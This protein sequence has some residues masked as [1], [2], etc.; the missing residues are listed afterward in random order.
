MKF[1]SGFISCLWV[2]TLVISTV[3]A[4][5]C[6]VRDSN[7]NEIPPNADIRFDVADNAPAETQ[8]G[9]LDVVNINAVTEVESAFF[10]LEIVD[11]KLNIATTAE[12]ANVEQTSESSGVTFE[13]NLQCADG[14]PQTR[15]INVVLQLTNTYN[16]QFDEF[17]STFQLPMPFPPEI[18]INTA[19]GVTIA[20]FDNDIYN[21][22]VTFTIEDPSGN[23]YVEPKGD[24]TV[25]GSPKR[26]YAVALKS[27][28]LL[29]LSGPLEVTIVAQDNE[30][31]ER[32]TSRATVTI[33]VDEENSTPVT[34]GFKSNF[35]TAIDDDA[36]ATGELTPSEEI[37]LVEAPENPTGIVVTLREAPGNLPSFDDKFT[38][39]YDVEGNKVRIEQTL[40]FTEEEEVPPG[41]A[42]EIEVSEATSG[43]VARTV[44]HVS[45]PVEEC[46]VQTTET[47]ITCPTCSPGGGTCPTHPTCPSCPTP[48]PTVP[49]TCPTCAPCTSTTPKPPSNIEFVQ[50]EYSTTVAGDAAG[51]TLFTVE[52]VINDGTTGTIKYGFVASPELSSRLSMDEVTGELTLTRRASPGSYEFTLTAEIVELEGTPAT[53]LGFLDVNSIGECDDG[54]TCFKYALI[55]K[56]VE[57]GKETEDLIPGSQPTDPSCQFRIDDVDAAFDGWF[58][59]D[60]NTGALK[61]LS[62]INYE[63]D[64]FA[65]VEVPQVMLRLQ[66]EC[67]PVVEVK[68]SFNATKR[69]RLEAEVTKQQ[70][71][72]VL[73]I[74]NVNDHEPVFEPAE[75]RVGYPNRDFARQIFPGAIAKVQATDSDKGDDKKLRYRQEFISD[76]FDLDEITGELYPVD[77]RFSYDNIRLTILALD[78][79]GENGAKQGR[80]TLDIKMVSEGQ[81]AVVI[82]EGA[83]VD[84]ADTIVADLNTKIDSHLWGSLRNSYIAE[85]VEGR[86]G[87]SR[88]RAGGLLLVL[89]ALDKTN[90]NAASHEKIKQLLSGYQPGS[91]WTLAG[92]QT[93]EEAGGWDSSGE[94]SD[95][96]E[97]LTIA[98]IVLAVIVALCLIAIGGIIYVTIFRKRKLEKAVHSQVGVKNRTSFSKHRAFF[99]RFLRRKNQHSKNKESLAVE[100]AKRSHVNGFDTPKKDELMVEPEME[101]RRKSATV[102]FNDEPEVIPSNESVRL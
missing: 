65:D 83:T 59:I 67:S 69:A 17:I 23:F 96:D 55:T 36:F 62:A 79:E 98:V 49:P 29:N 33:E 66:V 44:L 52:A 89:Y 15:P 7:G 31:E 73:N 32:R 61:G 12:F 92:I 56:E 34:I 93:W 51:V 90:W 100:A 46:S 87:S 3:N 10:N 35:Y 74:L 1:R 25:G 95:P 27:K 77:G 80:L 72:V 39:T 78:S 64:A 57:E 81:V 8:F 58:E 20:A 43:F 38:G 45:L 37:E 26:R 91:G 28:R 53:A 94:G 11:G 85:D 47:P 42:L 71:L 40:P 97:G 99:A 54:T 50:P 68:D 102:K 86:L 2:A 84:D 13:I 4:Q 19:Y 6:I 18:E 24:F 14:A 82:A 76:E 16:P 70:M 21:N 30:G 101:E 60:I 22:D 41:L 75:L 88:A 9:S 5:N 63:D 48:F